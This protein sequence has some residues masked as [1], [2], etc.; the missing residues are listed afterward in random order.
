MLKVLLKNRAVERTDY[1]N[2]KLRRFFEQRL[3]LR[4]EFADYADVV[5]PCLAVPVLLGVKRAEFAES[6]C[7]KKHLVL[8]VIACHN[9]RPMNHRCHKKL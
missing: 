3:S 1:F 9:L 4:A 5:S 7:G 8:A 2:V 6:V